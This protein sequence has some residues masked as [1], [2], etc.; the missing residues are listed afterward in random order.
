MLPVWFLAGPVFAKLTTTLGVRLGDGGKYLVVFS[1]P[2]KSVGPIVLDDAPSG[3]MQGLRC[4]TRTKL[5][6][7][8][9]VA[10]AITKP[11]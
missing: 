9:A 3:A 5:L 1:E 4:T 2:A 7:S 8:K 10:E 11:Y 6:A